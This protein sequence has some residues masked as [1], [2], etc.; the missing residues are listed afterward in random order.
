[1]STRLKLSAPPIARDGRVW[2][3]YSGGVD[4]TALLHLLSR[5]GLADLRAVHVH[6]ALQPAA[7]AWARHCRRV[8]RG[9]G[10][11]LRVL[12]ITVAPAGEGLEAAARAARY[13]AISRLLR[14]GDVLAVAHQRDDQ[15]ETVLFRALRGTGIAGLGA[16][17]EQEALGAAVLWRPLLGYPRSRVLRYAQAEGLC[18]IDDPH[19]EDP[20]LARSF[21]RQAVLPQLRRHFPAAGESLARL[22]RHAQAS[23]RLLA[24]L[25]QVDAAALT[26]RG[27]GLDVDGLLKLD[28]ERRR[29]LLYHRW[30]DLGLQPPGEAWYARLEREVLGSRA[31][32]EPVLVHGGG[33]ARRYRGRLYLMTALAPAPHG[34]RLSWPRARRTLELP[35]GCGILRSRAAPPSGLI[36][37]FGVRGE[38]LRPAGSPHHRSLKNLC[39]EAGLPPWL[40]ER[41]PLIEQELSGGAE[42]LAVGGLWRSARA[43]ELG[44]D[45]AWDHSIPGAPN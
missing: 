35:P 23:E 15:A 21:L 38:R 2:V 36:V 34:V 25:A 26:E 27:A 33:E 11:P 4:S 42:L 31:D 22:A 12:R 28:P 7:D 30:R 14:P 45:F 44:L 3:G 29:N 39:Q 43:V 9:L 16:M 8:C 1:M 17:R 40:R 32:A 19:N 41:M 37:R 13:A 5:S 20:S 24:D 6:H 10:V 18:W